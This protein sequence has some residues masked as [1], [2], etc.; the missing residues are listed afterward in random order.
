[1]EIK[2][3]NDQNGAWDWMTIGTAVALVVA[4]AFLILVLLPQAASNDL[5]ADGGPTAT[6]HP[7][8][9]DRS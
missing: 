5:S 4:S 3:T 1:M 6:S 7:T 9:S 8:S 2:D